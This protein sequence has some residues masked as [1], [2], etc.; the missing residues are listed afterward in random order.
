MSGAWAAFVLWLLLAAGL[1]RVFPR[2]GRAALL[3]AAG[4]VLIPWWG[5]WLPFWT[6]GLAANFSVTL[7]AI[8]VA[9]VAGRVF[10]RPLFG[11][12]EWTAAWSFGVASSVLL[13]PSALGLG[14]RNFDA[15]ALGWPWLFPGQSFALIMG[16]ALA[17]AALLWCGNRF[18]FVLLLALALYP[19]GFQE[20]A[21]FWD[22]IQDPVY[23]ILSVLVLLGWL[24]WRVFRSRR[25][26]RS[27]GPS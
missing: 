13:Y 9:G 4:A 23:G 22:Y 18:G 26:P 7:A 19:T 12:K 1:Q 5:H 10:G 27:A 6:S 8:L 15:Y 11:R 24:S 25:S 2:W 20:S 17:A 14:P 16:V 3:L 21:N